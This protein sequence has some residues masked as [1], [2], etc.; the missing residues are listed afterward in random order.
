MRDSS[1]NSLIHRGAGL[2][3][4]VGALD[5]KL[6]GKHDAIDPVVMMRLL[7]RSFLM[8]GRQH[9]TGEGATT[10]LSRSN[11]PTTCVED[12]I[13]SAVLGCRISKTSCSDVGTSYSLKLW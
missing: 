5:G 3:D 2:C 10:T 8:V 12:L 9:P 4:I 11:C 13:F 6:F 7:A 1:D